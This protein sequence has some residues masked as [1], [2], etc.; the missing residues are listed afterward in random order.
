MYPLVFSDP[1]SS[2][3]YFALPKTLGV[4]AAYSPLSV[5]QFTFAKEKIL[6]ASRPNCKL[7]LDP[8]GNSNLLS[9]SA[10]YLCVSLVASA[11]S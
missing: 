4:H 6:T 11:P 9:Y 5:W 1:D 7:F 8:V 3:R 2:V 10:P